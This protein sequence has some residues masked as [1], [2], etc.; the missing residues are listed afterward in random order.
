[1]TDDPLALP[2]LRRPT[3]QRPLLGL[4]VLAVEDSR[5]ASE[6]LRLLCLRSGA[7]L[8]RADTIAAARRHLSLYRPTAVIVD[9]GL[10]DGSGLDLLAEL[11]VAEPRVPV[12]IGTSGDPDAASPCEK[13]GAQAFLEKPV[14]NLASFQQ[15]VLRHLPESM[16]PSG[17]RAL[18][19]DSIEPDPVA[20]RD[21][22]NIVAKALETPEDQGALAYAAQFLASVARAAADRDLTAA[23]D[24]LANA[25][26]PGGSV[27][28]TRRAAV[29][30]ASGLIADRLRSAAAAI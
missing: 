13:V 24:S 25:L 28:E 16:R 30:H 5:F 2:I 4:T 1:M 29:S 8:R 23:A 3:P 21:D 27:A 18:S 9:L 12:L 19:S 10:P 15:L 17:L 20:L 7:R 26:S 22:L 11:H 14:S 6:A